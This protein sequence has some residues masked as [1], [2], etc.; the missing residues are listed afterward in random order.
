[1]SLTRLYKRIDLCWT[2]G[3]N[4]VLASLAIGVVVGVAGT[5]GLVHMYA[6]AM[7]DWGNHIL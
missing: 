5:I 7:E 3:S 6:K 4:H 2:R 1:M